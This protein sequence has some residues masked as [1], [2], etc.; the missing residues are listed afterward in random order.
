MYIY[1]YTHTPSKGPD[2]KRWNSAV[3][4]ASAYW[5]AS[6]LPNARK[7]LTPLSRIPAM[8]KQRSEQPELAYPW[9]PIQLE[10]PQSFPDIQ[11]AFLIFAWITLV[12][13][14]RK[15]WAHENPHVVMVFSTS[16]WILASV[17]VRA[18]PGD[19]TGMICIIGIPFPMDE[20]CRMDWN[21][22]KRAM[23]VSENGVYSQTANFK[24]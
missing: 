7:K 23:A 6:V 3:L 5:T 9:V 4:H 18:N 15:I 12:D 16:I 19:S 24:G 17:K 2:D 10:I 13:I 21:A 14:Y 8:K 11:N 20:P 1:I 22:K